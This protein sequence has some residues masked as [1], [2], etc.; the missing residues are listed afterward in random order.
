MQYIIITGPQKAGKSYCLLNIA[1]KLKMSAL[2]LGGVITRRA[3]ENRESDDREI[4]KPGGEDTLLFCSRT[5]FDIGI[6]GGVFKHSGFYF[7]KYAFAKGNEW[8]RGSLGCDVL[9]ID[10]IGRLEMEQDGEYKWDFM[11]PLAQ[12]G[13]KKQT[14]LFSVKENLVDKFIEKYN[15]G[16]KIIRVKAGR[17]I[18]GSILSEMR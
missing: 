10:E 11:L 12:A 8:I 18:S 17:D 2:T 6:E 4:V 16:W 13:E 9:F 3:P 14:L 15:Y 5:E 1:K 7:S